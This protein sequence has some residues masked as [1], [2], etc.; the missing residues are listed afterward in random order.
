MNDVKYSVN[1]YTMNRAAIELGVAAL[2]DEAYFKETVDKVIRTRER[3][4]KELRALGFEVSDSKTNFVF[5]THP[6][7]KAREIFE[8]L[9]EQG[10]YVRYFNKPR[11]DDHLRIT[12][13]TDEE[14]DRLCQLLSNIL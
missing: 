13:G 2:S 6:R 12:I 4:K 10:V 1:S 7:K 5:C 9:R 11:I 14:M 3:T 8:N